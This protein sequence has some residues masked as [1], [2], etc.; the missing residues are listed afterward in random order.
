MSLNSLPYDCCAESVRINESADIGKYYMN[1]PLVDC[2]GCYPASPNMHLQKFGV[3]LS[4]NISLV[5]ISSELKGITRKL[6]DCP[7]KKFKPC[8]GKVQY[9][10][11]CVDDKLKN[12]K[13]C[14]FPSDHTRM[15]NPPSTLRGTG[16]NRWEWLWADPQKSPHGL[17]YPFDTNINVQQLS[18]DNHRPCLPTPMEQKAAWP[19]Y[20]PL[21]KVNAT[22]E[23]KVPM[24]SLPG[25]SPSIHWN[26][27][28]VLPNL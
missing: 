23:Y 21:P 6:S 15:S 18:K 13:D 17:M 12:Y 28:D 25:Y 16:W 14:V 7:S 20:N 9:G 27:C 1:Q 22:R 19:N 2:E 26:C 4:E 24:G 3:S 8:E 11:Q 10:Y 5:D